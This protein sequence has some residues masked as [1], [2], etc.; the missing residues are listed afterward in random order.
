MVA[1]MPPLDALQQRLDAAVIRHQ[2]PG[3]VLGL[4]YESETSICASGSSR[5]PD[6]PPV[7][8][9]TLFLI[10]SITKVWT[11]T[12]VMQLVDAGHVSLDTPVNRYL[13]P[14]L[15][16]ADQQVADTVTVRQLLTHTAGFF[17]DAEE[18]PDRGADAVR[19]TIASYSN[20]PQLHRPGR[21]LSYSNAGFNVLGRLVEC[22]TDCTW[23]RALREQILDPLALHDTVTFPEDAI[24]HP[25]AVGHEVEGPDMLDFRPVS[26]W[27]DPRGGGPCGSTLATTAADLLC[28]AR[29]HM[30][31]GVSGDGRR[32]LSVGSAQG[33][34]EAQV[35]QPNPSASPA[36]GLGWAVERPSDPTVVEHDGHMCGSKATS[37]WFPTIRS[38]CAYSRTATPR[39]SCGRS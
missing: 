15:R 38:P 35:R 29:L 19:R 11:A 7:T 8:P 32:L 36:W 28:F 2:V 14:P 20:L 3:A 13:D 21:L 1:S 26:V 4:S 33:M 18:P 10:A 22:L 9:D 6:G 31:D 12:L 16:L 27:L 25:V 30:H 24:L 34:R 17:G 37:S 23:D 39:G 5:L